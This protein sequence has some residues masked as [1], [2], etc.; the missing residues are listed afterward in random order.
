[1]TL[2][3]ELK[4]LIIEKLRVE[5]VRPEEFGDEEQLFG[6]GL[7]LDSLDAVELVLLLKKEYG[8]DVKDMEA[9]R[10]AFASTRTLAEFVRQHT[11]RS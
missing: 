2:E 1:L 4:T 3:L 10:S 7:G 11:G 8:I 9:V 5:D 6:E